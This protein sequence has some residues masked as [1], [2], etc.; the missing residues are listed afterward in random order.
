MARRRRNGF[1]GTPAQHGR[2]AE[3]ALDQAYNVFN[4]GLSKGDCKTR[5]ERMLEASE[6]L[7]LALGHRADADKVDSGWDKAAKTL[8]RRIDGATKFCT[9]R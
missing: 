5:I 2:L 9:K 6:M 7:G 3:I 4:I 1:A 8:R